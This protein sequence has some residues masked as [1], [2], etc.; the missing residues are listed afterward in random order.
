M[1]T[2]RTFHKPVRYFAFA[3]AVKCAKQL[4]DS[5]KLR[6]D[7]THFSALTAEEL[8]E[9]ERLVN[10]QIFKGVDV[11]TKEMQI[12]EAKKLGAM[13]LFGEK[14]GDIVRVVM[15]DEFSKEFCGGTHIENTAKIGLFRIRSEGSVAS[16]VRRIEAVTGQ[17]VLNMLNDYTAIMNEAMTSLKVT[18]IA[19]LVPACKSTAA[20]LKEKDR[21]IERLTAKISAL[22]L[23]NLFAVST[24]EKGV[25]IIKGKFDGTNAA[26]LKT[27]GDRLL[28]GAPKSVAVLFGVDGDK[29]NLAVICGKE[30]QE[31]GLHAGKL[32]KKIAALVDG[33]GGGKPERAMAGVGTI[34]KIDEA[35]AQAPELILAEVQE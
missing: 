32:I 20:E 28:D 29:A 23:D 10:E 4:V 30:A 19:N 25:R 27:M 34:S 13:A 26:M 2:A 11:I 3:S 1:D 17:G 8:Q 33:K 7:F 6:F 16:G 21:E 5:E 35:L 22:S 31:K 12:D 24:L 14:Y 18:N 9:I 15:I